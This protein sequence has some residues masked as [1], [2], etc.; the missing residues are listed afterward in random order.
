MVTPGKK[1]KVKHK[2]FKTVDECIKAMENQSYGYYYNHYGSD[3]LFKERGLNCSDY[4]SE[5]ISNRLKG[6]FVR[7]HILR[8]V[9]P[10]ELGWIEYQEPVV[11]PEVLEDLRPA[12][13]WLR[14]YVYDYCNDKEDRE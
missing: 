8:E 5:E 13:E 1:P 10:E 14:E 4:D 3:D 9:T 12:L 11:D 2:H 7:S 6:D